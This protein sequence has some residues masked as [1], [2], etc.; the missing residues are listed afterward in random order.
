M[1][2]VFGLQ[3]KPEEIEII[4]YDDGT[5]SVTRFW[6][7]EEGGKPTYRYR[8]FLD[9]AQWRALEHLLRDY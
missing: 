9:Q 8:K 1:A 7:D 6:R 4:V 3:C 2:L 5:A